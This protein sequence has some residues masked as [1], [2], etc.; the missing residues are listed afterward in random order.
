MFCIRSVLDLTFSLSG[1]FISSIVYS[2]LLHF[3]YFVSKV[4]FCG[5]CSNS[6]IFHFQNS[7]FVFFIDYISIFYLNQFLQLFICVFLDFFKRFIHLLQF[8]IS[9]FF[10]EFVYFSP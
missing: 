1:G 3:L 8:L 2:S 9:V 10:E 6:Q 7:L 5:I 4:F